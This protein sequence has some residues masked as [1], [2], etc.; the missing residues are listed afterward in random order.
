[1]EHATAIVSRLNQLRVAALDASMPIIVDFTRQELSC[2]DS[3]LAFLKGEFDKGPSL[4]RSVI[5]KFDQEQ[6]C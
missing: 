1:M 5:V 3:A 2:Y 6:S 4:S